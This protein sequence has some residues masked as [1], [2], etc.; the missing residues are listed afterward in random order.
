MFYISPIVIIKKISIEDTQKK[1]REEKGHHYKKN[2]RN[3]KVDVKREKE[4]QKSYKTEN[5]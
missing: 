1:M 5:N 4:G 3:T 2:L